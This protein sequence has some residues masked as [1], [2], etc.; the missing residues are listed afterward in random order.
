MN[1]NCQD[2]QFIETGRSPLGSVELPASLQRARCKRL[3][4]YGTSVLT[5]SL[6]AV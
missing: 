1:G 3:A 4:L 2:R 6:A 5:Y